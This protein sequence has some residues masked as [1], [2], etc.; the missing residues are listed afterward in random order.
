MDVFKKSE[1]KSFKNWKKIHGETVNKNDVSL[2]HY[3]N[4]EKSEQQIDALEFEKIFTNP[5]FVW[6]HSFTHELINQLS[7][8]SGFMGV[9]LGERVY[10]VQKRSG[11]YSAGL[12]IYASTP[13]AD[14]TLGGLTSLVNSEILPK[15]I[16]KVLNKIR[17]CSNDPV[18]SDRQ[19]NDN[20][21]TGAA[22]HICLMNSE[23]SCSYQNKF[24]D[25]NI[26]LETS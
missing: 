13:G 21:R 26:I 24:L 11:G 1:T 16:R 6:W 15:I 7:I 9:S 18:C 14:G 12:F 5:L 23:T 22:C 3:K 2:Q 20:R 10:C 8:D 4:K 17:S 25:R 19:I